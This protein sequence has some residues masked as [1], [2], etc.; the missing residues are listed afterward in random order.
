MQGVQIATVPSAPA[1]LLARAR[2]YLELTR[3]RVVALV[4]LTAGPVLLWREADP[5]VSLGVLTGTCGLAGGCSALNAWWERESD[6]RMVRTR[7]RPLPSGRLGADDAL[8]FGIALTLASLWALLGFGGAGAFLF[9]AITV[10]WYVGFYTIGLKR[11]TAQNIVIG[12][13]AGGTAPLI[14]DAAVNGMPGAYAWALFAIVFLWTPP[15]FWA[16]ALYRAEEYA[17]AG[18]P[19]MPAVA[20]PQG[21]RWRM[22]A[23]AVALLPATLAPVALGVHGW[24]YGA[25]ATLAGLWLVAACVRALRARDRGT[26]RKVFFASVIHLSVLLM[27]MMGEAVVG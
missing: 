22:L 14:A 13:A 4:V 8:A 12:G 9:G 3:P 24:T 7:T 2:A 15:H 18:I 23:Y 27:A 5:V 16:I 1:A 21:T 25:V 20:G 26:D 19:M 17:A 10:A 6:G 11:R